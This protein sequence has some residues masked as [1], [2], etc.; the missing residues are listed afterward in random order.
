[1]EDEVRRSTNTGS[2][3]REYFLGDLFWMWI[4]KY[5]LIVVLVLIFGVLLGGFGLFKGYKKY[6]AA[7]AA[8]PAEVDESL[9]REIVHTERTIENLKERIDRTEGYRDNA[10]IL[11]MDASQV[12]RKTLIYYVTNNYQINTDSYYQ[13]PD[14]IGSILEYYNGVLSRVNVDKSLA[15]AEQPNLT[16]ANPVTSSNLKLVTIGI[17]TTS[18]YITI[19]VYGD[20]EERANQIADVYRKTV[21]DYYDSVCKVAGDHEISLIVDENSVDVDER[22]SDIKLSY[23]NYL[24]DLYTKLENEE[25][26]LEEL[27]KEATAEE[28]S[29]GLKGVL[30]DG[31]KYGVVGV[32]LGL[33]LSFFWA[34]AGKILSDSLVS[35][36]DASRRHRTAILGVLPVSGKKFSKLDVRSLGK[37]GL[38][39]EC[40]EAAEKLAATNI[41]IRAEGG[42][43]AFVNV[44]NNLMN[45]DL[46]GA[47][48]AE[49]EGI[50]LA[51]C[52]NPVRSAAAITELQSKTPV[53]LVVQLMKTN[54]K[55]IANVLQT[56]NS[57][58]NKVLGFVVVCK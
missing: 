51:V 49:L 35:V 23:E 36:D 29:Y 46:K 28:A 27:N 54:H 24:E 1:M 10:L 12:Y 50:D 9:E 4:A 32:V 37:L 45:E 33:I 8:T 11:Q 58:G 2:A 53:V 55:D 17:N 22:F 42:K 18:H 5:R 34:V 44:D 16:I 43:V 19:T 3:E 15:T 20:T 7:A 40:L 13:N 6:Q 52:E 14:N 39:V 31:I 30:K 21:A 47:M 56:C 26:A 25:T 41:K 38:S 57:F 48:A